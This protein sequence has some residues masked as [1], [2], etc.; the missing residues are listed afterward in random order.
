MMIEF[1]QDYQG[2][3]TAMKQYYKGD[4][5]IIPFAQAQELI[6]FGIA[7]EVDEKIEVTA[8]SDEKPVYI[9]TKSQKTKRSEQPETDG[10]E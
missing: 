7:K 6:G 1:L 3:E 9:S 2:R 10:G 4:R 8:M 5:T